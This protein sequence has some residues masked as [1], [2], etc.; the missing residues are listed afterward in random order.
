MQAPPA[1]HEYLSHACIPELNATIIARAAIIAS[2]KLLSNSETTVPVGAVSSLE[3]GAVSAQLEQL[4]CS[5][6]TG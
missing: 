2:D 4:V 1:A 6:C 3:L 5:H